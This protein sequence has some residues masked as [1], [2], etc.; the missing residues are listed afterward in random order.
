MVASRSVAD[1]LA[2]L[3]AWWLRRQGLTPSTAPK[4]IEA[5]VREAGWL[6]TQG[7][8]GVYLS[9]RARMPGVSRDAIDRAAIDG[10]PLIDVPGAH[11]RP[12]VLIPR[13]EMA[14]ALRLHLASYQKHAASYFASEGISEA[15]FAGVVAQ[16]CRLLDEGPLPSSDIRKSITHPDAGELLVGALVDLTIRGVVRRFPVD[17]RLDSSKYLYELRHPDDRPDLDAEGDAAAVLAKAAELFLRRHGPAT[18]EE[19]A[20]W[21]DVTKGAGRKALGTLGAEPI[22]VPGWAKEAWLLPGD[23]SAWRSFK[24]DGGDSVVLLPFRDPFVHMR[25]S[26]AA[27]A[28]DTSVPVLDGTLKRARIADVNRLHHHTIVSGGHIVGVWEYDPKT[29][30]VLT[31]LW[32]ADA[33]LRRRVAEAASKTARFIRDELGDA[34]ISAVDPP[35]KRTRRLAF[36]RTT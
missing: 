14:L 12:W 11:A 34:K 10:V 1:P 16:V 2:R 6:P 26:P 8:T 5:C 22:A 17:G 28:R 23:L 32:N 9:I 13:G 25:H 4:T 33:A 30:K 24:G 21:G 18:L 36:C 7:A 3:R 19:L 35:A 15:A 29:E 31:R 27:L 20:V